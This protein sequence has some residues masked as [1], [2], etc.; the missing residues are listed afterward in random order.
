MATLGDIFSKARPRAIEY[1]TLG[2]ALTLGTAYLTQYGPGIGIDRLFGVQLGLDPC[3]LCYYQRYPYMA[4]IALGVLAMLTLQGTNRKV[5]SYRLLTLSIIVL[6]LLA[7]AAIAGYHIGVERAWWVGPTTCSG[8]PSGLGAV[9]LSKA[10]GTKPIVRC[11]QPTELWFGIAMTTYNLVITIS[12]AMFGLF[13]F[14][15]LRKVD[16]GGS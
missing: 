10:L 16:R 8:G 7:D 15:G 11:D 2:A 9:D 3:A 5:Q 13:S 1:L 4:I 6:L 14:L 12:F